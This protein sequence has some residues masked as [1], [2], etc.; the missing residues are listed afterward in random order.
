M[1]VNRYSAQILLSEIGSSGQEL[2]QQKHVLCIGAGGLAA[3]V[4]PYLVAAGVG[5]I[6]IVDDDSVSISN[7]NR[8]VLFK[9]H[10]VGKL[11]AAVTSNYLQQQNPQ[12]NI[13]YQTIRFNLGN[14]LDLVNNCDLVIDCSDDYATKLAINYWCGQLTKPWV[15]A[16]VLGW[17]GQVV[18]FSMQDDASPCYKCFQQKTPTNLTSCSLSGVTGPAVNLIGSHQAILALQALLGQY[19]NADRLLVFDIWHLEMQSFAL[20]RQLDCKYHN[21][22]LDEIPAIYYH[23]LADKSSTIKLID[24]RTNEEWEQGHYPQ[25]IHIPIGSLLT[26]AEQYLS[27]DDELVIYCNRQTLSQLAVSNLRELGFK[28]LYVLKDGYKKI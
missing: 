8:Q 22:T 14:G 21:Q 16:S 12:V 25:A 28:K 15:Y 18:L 27:W 23:Q 5:E 26:S 13:N 1:V 20:K 4:L 3:S 9:E 6:T 11:K 2:L 19:H 24:V 10:D 7:L 17:D